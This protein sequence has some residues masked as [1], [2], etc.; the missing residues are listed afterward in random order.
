[1]QTLHS[2]HDTARLAHLDLKP[3]NVMFSHEVA[4][5]WDKVRLLDFGLAQRCSPGKAVF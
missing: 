3:E 5:N 4:D 2:L 1:M